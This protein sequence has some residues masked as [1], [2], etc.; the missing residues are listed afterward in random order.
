MSK[1]SYYFS[2]DHNS[3]S[4][5]KMVKVQMRMGLEG[6]GLYWCVIEMLHEEAGYLNIADT[7]S[8]AFALRTKPELLTSLIN[9]F[10][11][12]KKDQ[13]RFWSETVLRRLE[14]RM[15]KSE[16]AKN[17]IKA[18]WDKAKEYGRDTNVLPPN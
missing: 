2:H 3:R 8:Y 10:D 15:E 13:G 7:D 4:D 6:I 14:R 1:E 5:P 18:R 9:E 16:K 17:S 12:F 11:L